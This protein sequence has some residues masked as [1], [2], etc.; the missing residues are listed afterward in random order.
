MHQ[1]MATGLPKIVDELNAIITDVA[2]K[3]KMFPDAKRQMKRI[4]IELY[5]RIFDLLAQIMKWYSK[6]NHAWKIMKKDCYNDFAHALQDIRYW[7]DLVD[8]G[9]WNNLALELRNAHEENRDTRET[10]H[11]AQ[12]RFREDIRRIAENYAEA[13]RNTALQ[14]AAQQAQ[15]EHLSSPAFQREI[16][17][18]MLNKFF[19][20]FD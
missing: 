9:A 15:L 7:W 12:D 6:N 18:L 16:A 4:V 20:R 10:E 11:K 8:K 2:E 1:A 14:Q 3:F 13:Q 19:Q 17:D 5:T